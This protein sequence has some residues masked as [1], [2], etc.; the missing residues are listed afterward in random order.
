MS[1]KMKLGY[2]RYIVVCFGK[3]FPLSFLLFLIISEHKKVTVKRLLHLLRVQILPHFRKG[4]F[5]AIWA[6][7]IVLN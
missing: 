7:R 2:I 6:S 1:S 3:V 5:E 4:S